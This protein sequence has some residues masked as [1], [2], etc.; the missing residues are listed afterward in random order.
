MWNR[1]GSQ[2]PELDAIV[3]A[4]LAASTNEEQK[5][6]I[7]EADKYAMSQHWLIFG[8][9]SPFFSFVQPWIIGYSGEMAP[10]TPNEWHVIM[11]RLWIDSELKEAMGY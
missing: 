2:W 3:E 8:P 11:A 5:R 10:P 1:G 6:L 7:A 9:I 4:A